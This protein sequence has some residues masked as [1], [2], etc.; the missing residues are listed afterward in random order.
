MIWL[1]YINEAIMEVESK[2]GGGH[3]GVVEHRLLDAGEDDGLHVG[4]AGFVASTRQ[5]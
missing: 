5:R 3:P 2:E 4:A 1:T